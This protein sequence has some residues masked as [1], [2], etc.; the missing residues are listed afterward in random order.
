VT[1]FDLL[2][3]GGEVLDPGAG[4]AGLMDVAVTAGHI[5]AVGGTIDPAQAAK[6]L[7]V[8]GYLVTPGL[9]DLHV[10]VFAGQDLGVDADRYGAATGV[11]TLVDA[12]SSGA[13]LFGAF[14]RSSVERTAQRILALL[15]IATIGTT[16]IMLAR[17]LE[18]VRYSSIEAC[19][20]CLLGNTDIL[21]GVKAR[22]EAATVGQNGMEP[23]R[24]ARAAADQA[25][26]LLMVHIGGNPPELADILSLLRPGDVVT[27]CCTGW[28]NRLTGPAGRIRPE[29]L[30]ARDLGV[31]FDVGHGLRSF[32]CEVAAS[33]L[34]SGFAPDTIS[35]DLHA[36]S[37]GAV[38]DLPTVMSGF[39]ALGMSLPDVVSRATAAPARVLGR[40]E[41][42]SLAPGAV[43]DIAVFALQ[44]GEWAFRDFPGRVYRGG[45]R[46]LP[47][48]TVR[49]GVVVHDARVQRPPRP[50]RPPRP[51]GQGG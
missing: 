35:T 1:T 34:A 17:E 18:D 16:S 20:S 39:L 19:V 40:P 38:T 13:H 2:L 51:A 43:A 12:G 6:T 28:G 3:R 36:Y 7:D 27:H 9:I 15:N 46:L 50:E 33:M 10:H 14:R 11:T 8:T 47:V 26:T 44:R 49:S 30:A 21:V 22:I 4:L 42:G 32:D 45:Q 24:R 41:L 37:K 25:G 48:L 23:L 29:V 5:A 31:I